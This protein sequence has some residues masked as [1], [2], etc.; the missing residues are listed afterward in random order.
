MARLFHYI[1]VPTSILAV[2]LF[3]LNANAQIP[4]SIYGTGTDVNHAVRA[5]GM[6]D[7]FYTVVSRTDGSI[8][9]E[10]YIVQNFPAWL[11]NDTTSKWISAKADPF[12]A[13]N[14]SWTFRTSFNITSE[15]LSNL[16]I[17]GRWAVDNQGQAILLNGVNTGFN[18]PDTGFETF[19]SWH[20]FKLSS[21][22][23]TGINTLDFVLV[24]FGFTSGLRV[25]LSG[26]NTTAVPEPGSL[27][28]LAGLGF[29]GSLFVFRHLRRRNSPRS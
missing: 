10:S 5:N 16:V 14:A 19:N 26:S 2:F 29:S 25:E 15:A 3:G 9:T 4:F 20:P 13:V 27:A 21:G 6:I 11:P 24:D 12:S 28:L 22:F 7:S 8:G 23:H 17:E 18:I 1:V